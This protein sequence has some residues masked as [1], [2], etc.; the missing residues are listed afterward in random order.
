MSEWAIRSKKDLRCGRPGG[1]VQAALFTPDVL[2]SPLAA[3]PYDLRHAA[4]STWLDGGV[5]TAQVAV[6]ACHFVEISLKI[7]AKCLDGD[8]ELQRQRIQRALGHQPG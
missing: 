1:P 5:L 6:W 3:T 8:T 7:Y 2:A 4:A